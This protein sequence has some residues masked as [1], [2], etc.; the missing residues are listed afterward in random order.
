MTY[1]YDQITQGHP[2]GVMH[3]AGFVAGS[4]EDALKYY[5]RET[6]NVGDEYRPYIRYDMPTFHYRSDTG[7]AEDQLAYYRPVQIDSPLPLFSG[8][9]ETLHTTVDGTQPTTNS[10]EARSLSTA[11][12][13]LRTKQ[14]LRKKMMGVF[15]GWYNPVFPE[16]E[17]IT[18]VIIGGLK[19]G[20]V[21]IRIFPNY[22][23]GCLIRNAEPV[24]SGNN[25]GRP[26]FSASDQE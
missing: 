26:L 8:E 9:T 11:F 14:V 5:A 21:P 25:L 3:G 17:A 12:K 13:L 10:F 23:F 2:G 22:L 4:F 1:F 7:Q 24:A 20:P 18:P 6:G 16:Q 15:K 19:Y